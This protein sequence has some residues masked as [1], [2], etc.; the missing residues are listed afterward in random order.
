MTNEKRKPSTLERLVVKPL[1][2]ESRADLDRPLTIW[3][4]NLDCVQDAPAGFIYPL[5][6]QRSKEEK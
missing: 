4:L 5:R 6:P 1:E 2:L 3:T